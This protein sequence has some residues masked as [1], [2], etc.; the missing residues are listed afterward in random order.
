MSLSSDL[1]LGFHFPDWRIGQLF[2]EAFGLGRVGEI[3]GFLTG[4]VDRVGLTVVSLVRRHQSDASVV[5]IA[6]VPVDKTSAED[7]RVFDERL[8]QR[9]GF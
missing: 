9:G 1:C 2:D 7:F 3:E 5:M 6:I 8:E 4:F